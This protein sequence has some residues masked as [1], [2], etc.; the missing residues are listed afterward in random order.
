MGSQLGVLSD[1]RVV[2]PLWMGS[3]T[4]RLD[5]NMVIST[6]RAKV[7]SCVVLEVIANLLPCCWI[8]DWIGWFLGRWAGG[9]DTEAIWSMKCLMRCELAVSFPFTVCGKLH[10]AVQII[11]LHH[12]WQEI[13][14]G[15]FRNLYNQ[16]YPGWMIGGH[17]S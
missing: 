1:S 17:P 3:E 4:L 11:I 15:E 14:F 13:A 12:F 9:C 10:L 16:R 5:A 7:A 8:Y 6:R 2:L